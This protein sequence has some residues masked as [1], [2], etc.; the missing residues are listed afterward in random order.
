M[1]LRTVTG[2]TGRPVVVPHGVAVLAPFVEAG[3][4]GAYEVQFATTVL[5]LQPGTGIAAWYRDH[6]DHQLPV[7]MGARGPFCQCSETAHRDPREAAAAPAPPGWW[8]TGDDVSLATA[9]GADSADE[10]GAGHASA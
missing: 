1:T 10:P 6:L 5:R 8:D 9:P 4:F 7:L 2:P 3:V